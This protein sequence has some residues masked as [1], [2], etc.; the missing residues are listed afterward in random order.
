MKATTHLRNQLTAA[1]GHA[2]SRGDWNHQI[3]DEVLR[4]IEGHEACGHCAIDTPLV[5]P[6]A[7]EEAQ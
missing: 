7:S 5:A 4:V 2:L 3:A 1:I 6:H